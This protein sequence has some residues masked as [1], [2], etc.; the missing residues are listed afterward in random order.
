VPGLRRGAC[1]GAELVDAEQR[2]EG[3]AQLEDGEGIAV[4]RVWPA[5]P[6]VKLTLTREVTHAKGD[7]VREWLLLIHGSS[8]LCRT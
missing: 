8:L 1:V 2:E 5:Q 3:T 6:T 7:D 4:E